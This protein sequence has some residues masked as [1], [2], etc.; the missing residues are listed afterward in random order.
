MTAEPLPRP[1]A[2]RRDPVAFAGVE[3][4]RVY[5]A[6]VLVGHVWKG[7][8]PSGSPGQGPRW[9][10]RPLAGVNFARAYPTRQAAAEALDIIGSAEAVR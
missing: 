7:W 5:V 1:I 8:E 2:L 4:F 10:A 6:G 9:Y 3:G